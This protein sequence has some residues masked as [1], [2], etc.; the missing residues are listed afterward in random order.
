[1][2]NPGIPLLLNA[3]NCTWGREAEDLA[4]AR[5]P[6]PS[7]THTNTTHNH[8]GLSACAKPLCSA[9]LPYGVPGVGLW[10][11]TTYYF[12][13]NNYQDC[14]VDSNVANLTLPTQVG[15]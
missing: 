7:N 14:C 10:V 2:Q 6:D 15:G 3:C 8:H 4:P 5:P 11:N 13:S 9:L 1:V 12:I